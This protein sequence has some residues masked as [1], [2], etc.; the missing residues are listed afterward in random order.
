MK[1][2][3]NKFIQNSKTKTK[4]NI[5]QKKELTSQSKEYACF[6]ANNDKIVRFAIHTFYYMLTYWKINYP[7]KWKKIIKTSLLEKINGKT[8]ASVG[9]SKS[10]YQTVIDHLNNFSDFTQYL[11]DK[12]YKVTACLNKLVEPDYTIYHVNIHKDLQNKIIHQLKQ[13]FLINDITWKDIIKMY[14]S[15]KTPHEKATF[16]FFL[17]DLYYSNERNINTIYRNSLGNMNF[18]RDRLINYKH[19]KKTHTNLNTCNKSII[20]KKDFTEY[21][22][23]NANE[24]YVINKHSPYAT[25]MDKY[26]KPYMSGPSGSTALMF[27]ILFH[28][29]KFPFTYKNKIMILGVLI[30]DYIPLWHTINEILLSAYAEIKDAQIPVY[31]MNK[32]P[33]KYVK[34]LL[35]T[36]L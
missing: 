30:A 17:F 13:L 12:F 27:I 33:L 18:F 2:K 28:F 11:L 24:K 7:K 36:V 3:H 22:I 14:N 19:N 4:K 9:F 1:T 31:N 26:D 32:D 34:S 29:Y 6:L 15:L 23:Y 25:I 10:E 5:T 20:N 16:N 21:E 8:I 35:D